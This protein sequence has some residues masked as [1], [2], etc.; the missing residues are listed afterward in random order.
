MQL[1]CIVAQLYQTLCDPIYCSPPGSSVHRDSPGKN[2]G[3]CHQALLQRSFPTQGSN[4]CHLCCGRI[5]YW[6]SHRGSAST[7]DW[8]AYPF[9]MGSSQPRSQTGVRCTAGGFL[10]SWAIREACLLFSLIFD[11]LHFFLLLTI[12]GVLPEAPKQLPHLHGFRA[13]LWVSHSASW[14]Q[15]RWRAFEAT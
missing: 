5:L 8:V 2:T 3:V 7:L 4:P 12:G 10:T 9:S 6:L 13:D 14:S 15:G 1:L 11:P